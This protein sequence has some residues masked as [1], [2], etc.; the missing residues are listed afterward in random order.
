MFVRFLSSSV[1]KWPDKAEVEEA[2]RS[3]A[4]EVGEDDAGVVAVGYFGS[5]ARGDWGPPPFLCR[6]MSSCTA[7]RS[8]SAC[9]LGAASRAPSLGRS[10][11]SSIAARSSEGEKRAR[12]HAFEPGRGRPGVGLVRAGR[13]IG[14]RERSGRRATR[15]PPS[16][17]K[18]IVSSC[19]DQEG[20]TS[21]EPRRQGAK[22]VGSS[23]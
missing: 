21:W 10:S 2:V 23:G 9:S 22:L 3:W 15:I 6:R 1:L 13:V 11:G 16:R 7:P 8:G 19:G 14:A 20:A 4:L 5:Y 17:A 12:T 18:A